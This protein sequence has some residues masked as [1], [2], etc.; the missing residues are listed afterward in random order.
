MDISQNIFF[1]YTMKQ[2]NP[3][4]SQAVN[5]VNPEGDSSLA[6]KINYVAKEGEISINN[7]GSTLSD[8]AIEN[9][10]NSGQPV[11]AVNSPIK[12]STTYKDFSP[13]EI[14][15]IKQLI[16]NLHH[17]SDDGGGDEPVVPVEPDEPVVEKKSFIAEFCDAETLFEYLNNVNSEIT[18]ES[19]I[20]KSQLVALTQDDDWE[21]SHH[22]FFGSLNRI[23]S[24]IDTNNDDTFSFAEIETFIGNELGE[25]FI[26]YKNK[27][28]LY[29]DEI[30]TE[31]EKLSNQKKLEFAIAKAEEYLEAAGLTAQKAALDRLKAGTDMY[32]TIKVGQIAIADLNRNN[33]GGSRTLGAYN[34]YAFFIKNYNNGQNVSDVEI[35]SHDDDNNSGNDDLGI[36][37]DVSLLDENWYILVN[38]LVHELT[39]ATAYKYYSSDGRGGIYKSALTA[40]Y[41]AGAID[42]EEFDWYSN[43]WQTVSSNTE[44]MNRLDYLVSCLWGEY[45]AYQADADYNDSI[46][47][48]VYK[49]YGDDSTTAVNG[50]NE[51]DVIKNH[52]QELY[53]EPIPDYKWWSYA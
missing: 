11:Y 16:Y 49:V 48:D 33:S 17:K 10:L 20:T 21:D 15:N 42:Q 44:K 34:Y 28:N 38:T 14:S 41:N 50:V 13:S 18:K 9:I 27:I 53:D 12:L 45:S 35:W 2:A 19:G 37:L 25:S 4:Y 39:H 30:Q 43:N 23:F 47:Q 51:K 31:Y 8:E 46:G 40:L 22:D 1:Q 29:C 5:I 32:N 24:Q 3:E 52:I 36:T 26:Q 7:I 6:N